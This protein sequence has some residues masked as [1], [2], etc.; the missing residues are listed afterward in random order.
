MNAQFRPP[1]I[2]SPIDELAMLRCTD[3]VDDYSKRFIALSCHDTSLLEPQQIQ[4]FITGLSDP[5]RT[6]VVLQQPASLDDVVIF[7]RA[8]EQ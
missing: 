1:L 7:V 3:T 5:L 6:D 4:L 2:D 8:Y